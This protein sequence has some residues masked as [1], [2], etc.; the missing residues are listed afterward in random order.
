MAAGLEAAVY[1]FKPC[2]GC[3]NQFRQR[4][5]LMADLLLGEEISVGASVLH[6]NTVAFAAHAVPRHSD[7]AIIIGQSGVLQHRHVPQEGVWTLLGLQT[8]LHP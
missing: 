1:I 5:V 4:S 8:Q 3:L 6:G 2:S 7:G